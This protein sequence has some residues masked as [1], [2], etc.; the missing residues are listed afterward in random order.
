VAAA[1]NPE[2]AS[3]VLV[4]A[5]VIPAREQFALA[6][7]TYLRNLGAPEQLLRAVPRLL[8]S[9]IPGGG[10]VYADFD[11]TPFQQRMQQPVLMVYGTEDDSMPIVQAPAKVIEDLAV[12][13][14]DD[15][16]LRYVEGANHG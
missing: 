12:A 5:P 16:T 13:G 9:E 15:Y 6:T 4:S 14:N 7:D 2:V 10:F 3:V 11:V 1:E 8:G